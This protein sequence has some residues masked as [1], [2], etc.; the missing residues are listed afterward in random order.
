MKKNVNFEAVR[1]LKIYNE[2]LK[3]A[4][5]M[6]KFW[7]MQNLWW[8]FETR[9]IYDEILKHAKFMTR[10]ER[11][12]YLEDSKVKTTYLIVPMYE[13]E[14]K[15]MLKFLNTQFKGARVMLTCEC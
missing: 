7:N 8:N 6:R 14:H 5:F 9:K 15:V 2:I 10:K 1:K 3:H 12:E 13:Q 4:K 11:K